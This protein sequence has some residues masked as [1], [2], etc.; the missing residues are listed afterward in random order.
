MKK[1]I[2]NITT[3]LDRALNESGRVTGTKPLTV[4]ELI[5]KLQEFPQDSLVEALCFRKDSL[6][7]GC[8][9]SGYVEKAEL[10]GYGADAG[11]VYLIAW[12]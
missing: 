1:D 8:E 12:K 3:K 4:G 5:G 11:L 10:K 9:G 2:H 7:G 6:T